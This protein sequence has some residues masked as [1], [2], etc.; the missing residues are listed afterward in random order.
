MDRNTSQRE[1]KELRTLEGLMVQVK[2][3]T[4]TCLGTN[5][6]GC[7]VFFTT[8]EDGGKVIHK[9]WEPQKFKFPLSFFLKDKRESLPLT[10]CHRLPTQG[11]TISHWSRASKMSR[12]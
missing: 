3:K 9:E 2:L 6:P 8:V 10:Q 5:L 4:W 12:E 7:V 1:E 11:G